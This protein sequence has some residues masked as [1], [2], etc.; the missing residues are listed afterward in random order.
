MNYGTTDTR[1]FA[2]NVGWFRTEVLPRSSEIDDKDETT[3][4]EAVYER[5]HG[6]TTFDEP[7]NYYG[8]NATTGAVL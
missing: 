8:V 5:C 1:F 2:A 3:Y 7:P 6:W 4:I